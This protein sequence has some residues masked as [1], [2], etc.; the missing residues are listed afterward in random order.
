MPKSERIEAELRL[1]DYRCQSGG[2]NAPLPCPALSVACGVAGQLSVVSLGQHLI[3]EKEQHV[4]SALQIIVQQA[5]FC[6]VNWAT[7]QMNTQS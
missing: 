7:L 4:A 2:Q 3:A 6:G 1:I 5:G